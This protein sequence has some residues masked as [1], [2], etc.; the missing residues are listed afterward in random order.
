MTSGMVYSI[1]TSALIHAWRRAYPPKRFSAVWEN[2]DR[3]I[4]AGRLRASIEVFNELKRKDDDIAKWASS[5]KKD[6][7]I[8]IDDKVQDAV[9]VVLSKF[10]KLVDTGKGKS[11]ADPFVIALAL[12]ASPQCT[13][14]TQ[15]AGGTPDKPKIPSVCFAFGLRCIDLLTLFDDE[16]WSF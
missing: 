14:I 2:V 3:L 5:R 13:V 9:L 12:A 4:E 8:D 11:G 15:E 16:D 7:F 6:L 10:P 1:D